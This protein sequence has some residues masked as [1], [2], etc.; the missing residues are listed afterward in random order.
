MAIF[1]KSLKKVLEGPISTKK[2]L[3]VPGDR[4]RFLAD[5]VFEGLKKKTLELLAIYHQEHPLQP[6][7]SKEEL[8]TRLA[9]QLDPR[10]FQHLLNDLTKAAKIALDDAWVRLAEYRVSLKADEESLRH[11]LSTFYLQAGLTPPTV[12]ETLEKF[13]LVAPSQVLSMLAVLVR[14]KFLIKVKEDLYFHCQPLALLEQ[15]FL[16]HLNKEGEI[17]P[18][19]FKTLTGLTRKFSIPLLEYFD[20]L[21]LTIRVGDKRLL[22]ERRGG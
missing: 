12:K 1:G 4:E 14:D 6:G 16:A 9:R 8:R 7:L 2:I 19:G 13:S 10:L 21:K 3:V 20:R 15:Q 18:G 11:D 17:D 5:K 22:R